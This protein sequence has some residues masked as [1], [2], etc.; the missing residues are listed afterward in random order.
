[1]VVLQTQAKLSPQRPGCILSQE[2]PSFRI[3]SYLCMCIYQLGGLC[4]Y[5]L[6]IN[7]LS[8]TSFANVF[9][10]S[11]GFLCNSKAFEFRKFLPLTNFQVMLR[12][13]AWGPHFESQGSQMTGMQSM[14]V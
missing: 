14:Y 7:S 6:E 11:V 8:V 12:L 3:H 9:S 5:I 4:L 2:E 13:L 1:M 10:H